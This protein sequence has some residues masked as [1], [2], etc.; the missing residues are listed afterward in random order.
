MALFTSFLSA[1][2]PHIK[3]SRAI[4]PRLAACA[5]LAVPLGPTFAQC[6]E[7]QEVLKALS[8]QSKAFEVEFG[9]SID[10]Q[11]GTAVIGV[12]KSDLGGYERRGVA[13]VYVRV[14]S[15]WQE[16][17]R[18]VA[19]DPD[20]NDFFGRS[21]AVNGDRIAVGARGSVYTFT[22]SGTAWTQSAK[23]NVP[24]TQLVD[25]V[26][27]SSEYLVAGVPSEPSGS[28]FSVGRAYVYRSPNGNTW[29]QE[30]TLTPS[31]ASDGA[32][33]GCSV[34]IDGLELAVGQG[35]SGDFNSDTDF[36]WNSCVRTYRR[37]SG[38]WTADQELRAAATQQFNNFGE[39]V[40]IIG[41]TLA[42]GSPGYRLLTPNITPNNGAAYI[43]TRTAPG[44]VWNEFQLLVAVD[45]KQDVR[46]GD[47]VRL[48]SA[49]ELL[50]G[51][52]GWVPGLVTEF[53]GRPTP[54]FR[55]LLGTE[56]GS[57]TQTRPQ[58]ARP[59]A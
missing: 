15:E 41:N 56:R 3:R 4:I 49:T 16:Q 17:A 14:G 38:V 10:I 36:R 53:V 44:A 42:V 50:I 47:T 35:G 25:A 18:L 9:S 2:R 37:I 21:V 52:P 57:R 51:A 45:H 6:G 30:A 19:S 22:R 27:L 1:L 55:R 58:R 54:W 43:F 33:F 13:Y 26:D 34:A 29:M 59:S 48:A 20:L 32:R 46:F 12:P 11:G 24:T 39:S 31:V 5:A 23:I 28:L 40:S 7:A 8:D